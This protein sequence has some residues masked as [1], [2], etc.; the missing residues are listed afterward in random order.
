MFAFEMSSQSPPKSRTREWL[1]LLALL[2]YVAIVLAAT[3]SPTPLDQ[4]YQ[5]AIDKVLSVL[6]RNGVP[7]WFGYNKLEFSA[8]VVMFIPLGFLIALLLPTKVWWLALIV[9]PGLSGAIELTQGAV[10]TER[11]ASWGDVLSN[12]VGAVIGILVAV[13]LRALVYHRD[14]KLIEQA[15]WARRAEQELV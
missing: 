5:S 13:I 14:E 4:G 12:S 11:F 8:N 2:G 1:A 9:C 10:L 15:L 6:H 3:L 7:E